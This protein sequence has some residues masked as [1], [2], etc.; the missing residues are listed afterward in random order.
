L[1]EDTGDELGELLLLASAVESEGVG[2][3]RC[4]DCGCECALVGGMLQWERL[5]AKERRTKDRCGALAE[6]A[7]STSATALAS[8][9]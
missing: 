7:A 1:V 2:G 3:E 6:A 8:P 5:D 4:V 9:C